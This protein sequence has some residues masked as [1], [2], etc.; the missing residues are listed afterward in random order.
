LTGQRPW[1][2]TIAFSPDGKTLAV[3]DHPHEAV[4]LWDMDS[5]QQAVLQGDKGSVQCVTFAPDSRT[6]AAGNGKKVLLWD[7]RT[8]DRVAE[9]EHLGQV[10]GIAFSPDGKLMAVGGGDTILVWDRATRREVAPRLS[11]NRVQFSPDGRLLASSSGNIVRL[12][13][14]ATWQEVAEPLRGHTAVIM[15]LAFTPDGKTLATGD[16]QGTLWLWDV[17]QKQ[18]IAGRQMHAVLLISLSF[19]GGG[20]RLAT[21]G[22]DGIVR[23]WDVATLLEAAALPAEDGPGGQ[24]ARERLWSA[25][26]VATLTGHDGPVTAVAF[27]P[28]GNTLATGSSDDTVRLWHAPP[29]TAES[30]KP[31]AAPGAPPPVETIRLISLEL[32]DA[33][34][35]TLTV[36]GNVHRVDV[37]AVDGT[38]WHAR[39]SQVFEDLQE[40]ATY[41]IRFRAMADAPRPIMLYGQIEEPDWHGIGLNQVVSLTENWQDYRYQFRAKDLGATNMLRFLLGE[42]TGTVWIDDLTVTESVK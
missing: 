6:V 5:R 29:L 27:A 10:D 12:W 33:A 3:G 34:Q 40:G 31:A 13:D 28:D 14:V 15:C 7:T 9:F 19:S 8:K 2:G 32:F 38:N 22:G 30:H 36:E 24:A 4:K 1:F 39:L 26:W 25:A 18:P 23:L 11:G 35:A 37:T 42:R 17:A 41:T 16:W 21:A 20:R